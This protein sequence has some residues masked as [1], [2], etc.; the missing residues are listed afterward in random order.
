[1]EKIALDRAHAGP[2]THQKWPE[3]W[4]GSLRTWAPLLGQIC[5]ET[6]QGVRGTPLSDFDTQNSMLATENP[7][8]FSGQ[9]AKQRLMQRLKGMAQNKVK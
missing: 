5:Y 3:T 4:L 7:L 2:K 6:R 8:D 9:K 1:M